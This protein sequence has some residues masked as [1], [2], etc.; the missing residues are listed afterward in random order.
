M[1]SVPGPQITDLRRQGICLSVPRLNGRGRHDW[2]R[3]ARSRAG[4]TYDQS[5]H[6]CKRSIH[7]VFLL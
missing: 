5:G 1:P 3:M 4:K 6:E 7:K 2:Q